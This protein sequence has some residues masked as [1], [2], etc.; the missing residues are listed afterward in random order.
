[1]KTLLILLIIVCSLAAQINLFPTDSLMSTPSQIKSVSNGRILTNAIASYSQTGYI[2][3][4]SYGGRKINVNIYDCS[5]DAGSMSCFI[6]IYNT[7]YNDRIKTYSDSTFVIGYYDTAMLYKPSRKYL[8]NI[9]TDTSAIM[10]DKARQ[11]ELQIVNNILSASIK[12]LLQSTYFTIK[13]NGIENYLVNGKEINNFTKVKHKRLH[14][15]EITNTGK[16]IIEL[17]Y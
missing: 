9:N 1:M 15:I 12:Y 14:Q 4:Y 3:D 5:S 10:I 7:G 6:I 8:I 16:R 11:L 13:A 2:A 17:S